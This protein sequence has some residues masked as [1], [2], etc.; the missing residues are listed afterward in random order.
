MCDRWRTDDAHKRKGIVVSSYRHSTP[1]TGPLCLLAT[2]V[3]NG[4]LLAATWTCFCSDTDMESY[5]IVAH[6]HD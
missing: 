6:A 2:R 4:R 3:I 5:L 1:S